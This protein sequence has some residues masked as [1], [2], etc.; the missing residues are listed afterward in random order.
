MD[1]AGL[2]HVLRRRYLALVLC[3]V[4]GIAGALAL[5]HKT[6]P[7]YQ[8]TALVFVN[9]PTAGSVQ[10]GVQGVLLTADLLPSYAQIASSRS[11][12]DKVRTQLGLPDG[13]DQLRSRI[14]AKA[15][16]Q[17]LI[18][19]IDVKDH[20]PI[21]AQSIADATTQALAAT[22]AELESSRAPETVVKLQVVDA[23]TVGKK[24]SPRTKYNTALGVLL[25][26]AAGLVLALALEALDRSIKTGAQAESAT[27]APVL[28]I[29]PRWTR[30]DG[31][32]AVLGDGVTAETYRT[33]RTSVMFA[34]PD[35]RPRVV[36]VTSP[37]EGEGKTSTAVNLAIALAQ[38]GER[39]VLVDADLRRSSVARMLGLE[40][41]VGVTNVIMR[42]VALEDAVQ[43]WQDTLQVLPAGPTPVNPSEIVGSQAMARLLTDLRERADVVVID[44]PPVIPVTDAVVLSTQVDGVVL[45][46]RAGRTQRAQAGEA[47]RRLDGVQ[48]PVLGALLN[49]AKRRSASGY[50]AEY[51]PVQTR[52]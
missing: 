28:G 29:I 13:L 6:K 37:S 3:L 26:L 4:A 24:I 50:Y 42:T 39:T 14:S 30:S 5:N 8:S 17:K 49:A 47:R 51:R 52:V 31:A 36:M 25:G 23:A 18:L 21:R 12:V 33:L 20:D 40:G 22:V 19:E 10:S 43:T 7:V 15:L 32:I 9:V 27:H 2:M 34:D 41:A 11:V 1:A 38:S 45:V 35:N 16:P 46:V 48:S 44:S